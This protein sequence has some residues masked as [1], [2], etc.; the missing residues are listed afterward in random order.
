MK[1]ALITGISGQD[2]IYLTEFLLNKGYR[3]IGTVRSRQSALIKLPDNLLKRAELV[4]WDL[5]NQDKIIEILSSYKPVEIYN[6]AAFSS[7][8]G[9]YED[10]FISAIANG[11][12]YMPAPDEKAARLYISTG[13]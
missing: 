11:S 2:G 9:M 4:E 3:V 8:A 5:L 12:S 7:G 13:L 6:L 1:V 10:P